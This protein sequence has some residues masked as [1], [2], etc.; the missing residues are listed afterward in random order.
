M[1]HPGPPRFVGVG[2][3]VELAPRDPDPAATYSWRVE[4]APADSQLS[5]GDNPVE[6]FTADVPGTYTLE[7]TAPDGVHT[8]TIR[9]F[10]GGDQ[11]AADSV[12]R[13]GRSGWSG[14]QSGV[15]GRSGISG[16]SG[17]GFGSGVSGSGALADLTEGVYYAGGRP[18]VSL[19]GH[20]DGDT[21]V[22]E[23]DGKSHPDSDERPEDLD[24]EFLLDDRDRDAIAPEAV[25]I[26]GHTLT[27]PVAAL[28]DQLRIH[29]VSVG[30]GGHSVA[31]AIEIRSNGS[32]TMHNLYHPPEWGKDSTI[33]EIY[34][35]TFADEESQETT[36]EAITDKLDHLEALGVDTLW[37]TPVLE[38]DHAPHGYNITDFYAIAE[39]LG[40]LEAYQRFLDAAHDRG[41]S[42][43]F[44]MVL[45]HSARDHPFF[46][47]AYQNPDS[48]YYDWYDWQDSGEP[49]TYFEWEYIAN[50]N[51]G[52]LKVRRH[53]LDAV[54]KW[55]PLVD[56]FRC[57]MAW[58]V[59]NTFWKELR[60]RVKA[61]DEEFLLL[62][63]TI[64]YIPDFQEGMFDIHFDSTTYF[65]L[66]QIGNGH[67]PAEAIFDAVE[68]R[69]D[70]GFP[71]H[72]SF[73]LYYENHDET[74]YI[75]ECGKPAAEAAAGAIFTMP[76]PP[77][78]YAGQELGQRGRRDALAWEHAHEDLIAH[79]EALVDL[80]QSVPAL[81]HDA[82][83]ERVEYDV[84]E[85]D[86]ERVVAFARLE[87]EAEDA[88]IVVLNFGEEAATVDVPQA[89]DTDLLTDE[90]VSAVNSVAVFPASFDALAE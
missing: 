67:E 63:E 76:G 7:L 82:T 10:P 61:H 51:F 34:V 53:L 48:E 43:L 59:P 41:M 84:L 38:N 52:N 56:G 46:E 68:Q 49:E 20:I 23:A 50:F 45:N 24:V 1:H 78:I 36:F 89:E 21:V 31:D 72:A 30:E 42:V 75:V 32:V 13:S 11:P 62:D 44:D 54:D 74:R 81:S 16:R 57:D 65:T 22:I 69:A 71:D 3:V 47:D 14:F 6:H 26:D 87:E 85:G 15:S 37:L 77:M 88:A 55:A 4:S 25:T 9:A 35:R 2:E 60:D 5:L 80:R 40:G 29:A 39:D 19:S 64:P 12:S 27:V 58:A 70:L 28:P 17:S 83:F 33:Y 79:Y 86:D 90:P 73:M 8:L 18:R 66:R